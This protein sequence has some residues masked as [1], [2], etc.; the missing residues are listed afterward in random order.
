MEGVGD[1]VSAP[2]WSGWKRAYVPPLDRTQKLETPKG[3]Q[4]AQRGRPR[5]AAAAAPLQ[6]SATI[7]RPAK[8]GAGKR[9]GSQMTPAPLVELTP[10]E[11]EADVI[12]QTES[13]IFHPSKFTTDAIALERWV[14]LPAEE[15]ARFALATPSRPSRHEMDRRPQTSGPGETRDDRRKRRLEEARG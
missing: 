6:A 7:F 5:T 12:E 13:L 1:L 2:V 4:I 8:P 11:N 3:L 14:A 10:A 15:R 9:I